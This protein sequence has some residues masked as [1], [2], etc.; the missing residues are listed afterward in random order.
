MTFAGA[1]TAAK[2]EKA[3][4]SSVRF[5]APNGQSHARLDGWRQNERSVGGG[6]KAGSE[7]GTPVVWI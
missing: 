5:V 7:K 4:T 2:E 3:W 6:L 1:A